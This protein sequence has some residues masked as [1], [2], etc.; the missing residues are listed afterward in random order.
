MTRVALVVPT[1]R[2]ESLARFREAWD[3]APWEDVI[4]VYDGP[5]HECNIDWP[6][7]M[8]YCWEDHEQLHGPD[9]WIFSRRDS[10]CRSLGFVEA[11]RRGADFVVTLDDDCYPLNAEAAATFPADHVRRL[12]QPTRW[13]STVP[14]MRVRG[15]P[16]EDDGIVHDAPPVMANMGL[17]SGVPDLS[18]LQTIE[19]RSRDPNSP[20]LT[21]FEPPSG[22]RIASPYQLFPFCGMN[23]AFRRE[24]L[25]AM[26][27]PRMG[28]GSPFSRFDDIWCGLVLQRICSETGNLLTIGEPWVRHI[29]ASDVDVNLRKEAP[30]VAVHELYWRT[31][32]DLPIKGGDLAECV[33]SVAEKLEINEDAYLAE[34]GRAL[35]AWAAIAA[36]ALAEGKDTGWAKRS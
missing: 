9:A 33:V 12:G 15:M 20:L 25:P 11:V 28:A 36:N 10:A 30:G 31:I 17:W 4:V 7:A 3:R 22:N 8:I 27:F 29:R 2:P 19:L 16:P 5:R 34:W 21:D 26:Y 13:A 24:A 14:G 35:R 32:A 23:V 6:E 1:N 18:A